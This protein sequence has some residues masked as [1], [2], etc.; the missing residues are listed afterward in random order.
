MKRK[1]IVEVI[2][3]L[4]MLLFLFA[5]VSKWLA[6]R[7]F[8]N[9]INN[10]PFPNG[11]TPWIIYSVPPLQ[12]AITLSLMFERT[13]T[14]GFYASLILMSVYSLYTSAVLLNLFD[15]VPCSCG[16][17][18]RNL[19]WSRHLILDLFFVAI[20]IAGI[21][22]RRNRFSKDGPTKQVMITG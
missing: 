10:Q 15:Y 6:F 7:T 12:V 14:F 19:S 13:R 5:S 16:G 8:T 2:A 3:F 20:S 4:L 21:L 11:L 9:D 17:I 22:L 1:M 18:I